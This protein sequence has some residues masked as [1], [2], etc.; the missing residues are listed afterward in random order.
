MRAIAAMATS[1]WTLQFEHQIAIVS[2]N[3]MRPSAASP[4]IVNRSP[5]TTSTSS[6]VAHTWVNRTDAPASTVA[7]GAALAGGLALEATVAVGLTLGVEAGVADCVTGS[8]A[9]PPVEVVQA[10]S[11][12]IS[13]GSSAWPGRMRTSPPSCPSVTRR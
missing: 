6:C 2:R 3:T 10:T 8:L 1:C 9:A 11:M 7:L 12:A 4:A 13:A 5:V